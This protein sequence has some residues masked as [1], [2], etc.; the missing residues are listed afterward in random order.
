[1]G[2]E[3][4]AT[5]VKGQTKVSVHFA[6]KKIKGPGLGYRGLGNGSQRANN[7]FSPILLK[8]LVFCGQ[9]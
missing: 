6:R 5:A 3:V 1:M 9:I 7:S 2:T 8:N 4:Y